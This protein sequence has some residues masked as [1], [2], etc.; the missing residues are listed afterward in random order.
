MCT[1]SS[2][3]VVLVIA[4]LLGAAVPCATG[5]SCQAFEVL[6]FSKTAGFR[7]GAQIG[8]GL[9]LIQSLGAAQG[10]GVD[11]T[12]DET[13][14]DSANLS[15]YAAV[16]FL[17]TTGDILTAAQEAAL[18][19][20]VLAG[21]GFVGVHSAADT[22]YG[23]PFY[24]ALLGAYFQSH[25]V[26][27]AADVT[28][29][30]AT[31]PSTLGLPPVFSHTDEWYDFQTN[32]ASNPLVNVLLTV[33]ESTY[34]GGSMGPVHPVAWCQEAAGFGRSWYTALGHTLGTYSAPF[35]QDHLLGGIL[36]AAGSIRTATICGGQTY[37]TASGSPLLSLAGSQTSASTGEIVLTL[38]TPGGSG[39]LVASTCA[40]SFAAGA[41]TILIDVGAT[42][43][44]APA[45][46]QFDAAGRWRA[47]IPLVLQIP[48]AAGPSI[49]LQAAQLSPTLGLSNGVAMSLC[50]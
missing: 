21:G 16:V 47:A 25:P 28:V 41:L 23:W 44:F 43:S 30:D 19:S 42:S 4:S 5:Q 50:F 49:F 48:G 6:V 12:E 38:G 29:V 22:E 45:P 40:D 15:Q 17:H 39:L 14:I 11:H 9:A 8:A 34:A 3:R 2:A 20:Y 13:L 35:F 31:H 33:D 46:L 18:A 1:R 37:G 10:F 26:P 36:W 27:Q 7:H 32:P 24:G